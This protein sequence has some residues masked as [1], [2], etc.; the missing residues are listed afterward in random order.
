MKREHGGPHMRR[1]WST[2]LSII[3]ITCQ[4]P[5][6]PGTPGLQ[7]LSGAHAPYV[8]SA[9][10]ITHA[11]R[12][13]QQHLHPGGRAQRAKAVMN[14]RRVEKSCSTGDRRISKETPFIP[15]RSHSLLCC[16]SNGTCDTVIHVIQMHSIYRMQN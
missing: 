5:N 2:S 9:T 16:P 15:R 7:G 13:A 10:H 6:V 12:S 4:V 14:P 1:P 11:T 8:M 3:R